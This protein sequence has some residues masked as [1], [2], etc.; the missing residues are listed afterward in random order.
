MDKQIENFANDVADF[1]VRQGLPTQT[2]AD[3]DAAVAAYISSVTESTNKLC[4]AG[5]NHS[6]VKVFYH[7]AAMRALF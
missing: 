5:A 6:I 1:A 4:S 7:Q 2:V 3:F